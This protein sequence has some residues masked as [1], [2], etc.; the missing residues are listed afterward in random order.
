MLPSNSIQCI[1][2]SPSYNKFGVHKGRQYK[3]QIIYDTYDDNMNENEYQQ[4]QCD[5]LNERNRLLTP[6]GSLF[7]NHKD[8]CYCKRD[9]PPEQ[10]IL[11][12]NLQLYQASIIYL[13]SMDL[14][15]NDI[16]IT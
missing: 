10:F 9:Y 12:S 7:Y 11:H 5:L 8:R 13:R 14:F 2:T 3:G 4:W 1:V 16:L 15:M 6:T